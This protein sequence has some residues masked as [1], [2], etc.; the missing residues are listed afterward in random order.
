MSTVK[1][2]IDP[3]ARVSEAANI[4]TGCFIGPRVRILGA[5]KLEDSVRLDSN[6]TIY[7]GVTIGESTY[8][9]AG[10]IIGHPKRQ[11][12]KE[13]IKGEVVEEG[14]SGYSVIGERCIVRSGSVIYTDVTVGDDVE[15]GH[16]VVLR[17]NVT[18]GDNSLVGTNVV[19]DG[20]TT[21]GKRVS[22]QTG[23]YICRK[24]RIEDFV[25][26]G[27]YC[28][29]TNDKYVMQ[30]EAE[31]EGP[32]V[33]RG[34]SIGANSTLMAGVVIGKG[35]VVGAQAIVT[36]DVPAGTVFLGVPA[37]RVKKVPRGWSP[38]LEK[39]RERGLPSH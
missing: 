20:E 10:C 23:V 32:T 26:L 11:D 34:A 13:M 29:F 19:I 3:S 22:I 15:L 8:V 4:G 27:P 1:A 39:L 5:V 17:E 16:N 6:V 25:F 33:R 31:L 30:K 36:K 37:R 12:L 18:V 28:V 35:S 2:R 14:S 21:V 9:G 7:G 38:L 24:S